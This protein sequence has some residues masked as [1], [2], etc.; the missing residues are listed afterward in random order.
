MDRQ[1]VQV[2]RKHRHEGRNA[3]SAT[4][5]LIIRGT[6]CR[7][8]LLNGAAHKAA[9][10]LR[11][12]LFVEVWTRF[13]ESHK[14]LNKHYCL[15]FATAGV[16]RVRIIVVLFMELRQ[17]PVLLCKQFPFSEAFGGRGSSSWFVWNLQRSVQNSDL[18]FFMM[19]EKTCDS[20][21]VASAIP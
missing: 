5:F 10:E 11:E 3:R 9:N 15:I 16:N 13:A 4:G 21:N 6:N 12:F 19:R 8:H 18:Q 14:H 2:H 17:L 1:F 7:P 20:E